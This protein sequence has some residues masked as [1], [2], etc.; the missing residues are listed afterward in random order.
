MKPK[1]GNIIYIEKSWTHR[2]PT[3]I[4]GLVIGIRKTKWDRDYRI[5][6][7]LQGDGKIVEEP[8][9]IVRE[10]ECCKVIA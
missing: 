6:K 1:V 9:N 7:V 10:I 8:L 3:K 2:P 5:I 4:F